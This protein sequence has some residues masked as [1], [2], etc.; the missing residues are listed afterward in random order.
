MDHR[1][2]DSPSPDGDWQGPYQCDE[3]GKKDW[4]FAVLLLTLILPF[5]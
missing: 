4:L 3:E 2:M 1:N 5:F